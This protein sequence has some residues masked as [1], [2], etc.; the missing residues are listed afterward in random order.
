VVVFL[1]QRHGHQS[2]FGRVRNERL[3]DPGRWLNIPTDGL[4]GVPFH[5]KPI[6]VCEGEFVLCLSVALLRLL[7]PSPQL[8]GLRINFLARAE[9]LANRLSQDLKQPSCRCLHAKHSNIYAWCGE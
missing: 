5:P 3:R 6:I 1:T 4:L 7:T 8:G 9:A 2:S